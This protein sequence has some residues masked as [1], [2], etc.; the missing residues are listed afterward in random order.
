MADWWI[1]WLITTT[2]TSVMVASHLQG[3][4]LTAPVR[5]TGRTA[6]QS[7]GRTADPRYPKST[8]PR[9]SL[10][11][12]WPPHLLLLVTHLALATV[13]FLVRKERNQCRILRPLTGKSTHCNIWVTI[14]KFMGVPER[15]ENNDQLFKRL[16]FVGALTLRSDVRLDT[17]ASVMFV[18]TQLA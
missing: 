13:R 9:P 16:P 7:R 10:T 14:W 11:Q 5:G 12:S 3:S 2:D 17:S 1:D 18:L 8:F 4:D 15:S 6:V